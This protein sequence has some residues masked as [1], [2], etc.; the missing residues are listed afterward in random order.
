[1]KIQ[2]GC[3]GDNH[4]VQFYHG[5]QSNQGSGLCR[6]IGISKRI[7]EQKIGYAPSIQNVEN[8]CLGYDAL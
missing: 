3:F 5:E 2:T 8:H 1:M 4:F 7:H 6:L